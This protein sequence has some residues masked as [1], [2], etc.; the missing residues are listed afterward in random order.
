[1][2][3]VDRIDYNIQNVATSVEEGLKQLQKAEPT[4]K[5]GGMVLCATVLVILCFIMIY[6]PIDPQRVIAMIGLGYGTDSS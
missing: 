4:R 2:A 5:K 1:G 6:S 3:I